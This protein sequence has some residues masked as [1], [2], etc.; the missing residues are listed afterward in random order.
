MKYLITLCMTAIAIAFLFCSAW[1]AIALV[2]GEVWMRVLMF[3][4]YAHAHQRDAG[5]NHQNRGEPQV[6][7]PTDKKKSGPEQLQKEKL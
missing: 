1:Y 5:P 7:I 2:R 3:R 4:Q 6:E